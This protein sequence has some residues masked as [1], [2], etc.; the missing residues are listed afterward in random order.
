M[1]LQI[2]S[3]PLLSFLSQTGEKE[4]RLI[5]GFE[6]EALLKEKL[7]SG[8]DI[9]GMPIS[10]IRTIVCQNKCSGHGTCNSESRA[11]MCE[12]FWMPD[13]YYFWGI[14]EANCGKITKH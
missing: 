11:C 2:E 13:L 14:S 5:N 4:N 12:M 9:V 10:D 3:N 6:V 8:N 7:W 1:D